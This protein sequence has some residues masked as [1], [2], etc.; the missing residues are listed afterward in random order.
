MMSDA[1]GEGGDRYYHNNK[2]LEYLDTDN[3]IVNKK[4]LVVE[5]A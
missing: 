5:L 3:F 4:D 2:S 1:S